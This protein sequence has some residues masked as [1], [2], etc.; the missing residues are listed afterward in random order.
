MVEAGL[1]WLRGP[2]PRCLVGDSEALRK[3]CSSETRYRMESHELEPGDLSLRSGLRAGKQQ[4]RNA[5]L[6][7]HRNSSRAPWSP[8]TP[9]LTRSPLPPSLIMLLI[10]AWETCTE[11]CDG[12]KLTFSVRCFALEQTIVKAGPPYLL[13]RG[14]NTCP[15]TCI[16]TH[17]A[18]GPVAGVTPCCPSREAAFQQIPIRR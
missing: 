18:Q 6:G 14:P 8:P 9:R 4:K 10:F 15:N 5:L 12:T 13:P 11:V 3:V 1:G 2:L 7:Y 17:G 16:A